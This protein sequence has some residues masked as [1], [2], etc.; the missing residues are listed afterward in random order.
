[1]LKINKEG[2]R[3]IQAGR[4]KDTDAETGAVLKELLLSDEREN[5]VHSDFGSALYMYY[6]MAEDNGTVEFTRELD[7]AG[8]KR[9]EYMAN[10][11]GYR[12]SV[13]TLSG[14]ISTDAEDNFSM[15]L[16]DI[17]TSGHDSIVLMLASCENEKVADCLKM[18]GSVRHIIRIGK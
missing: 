10:L 4:V 9:L 3:Y 1:M 12:F 16:Y 14:K 8:W 13:D 5:Y 18:I 17:F 2:F 6:D 11:S 7:T 15:L